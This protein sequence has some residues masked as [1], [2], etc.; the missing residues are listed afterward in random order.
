MEGGSLLEVPPC[1]LA[2]LPASNSVAALLLVS[3]PVYRRALDLVQEH[4]IRLGVQRCCRMPF[5]RHAPLK[6]RSHCLGSRWRQCWC[7]VQLP[8]DTV[9]GA[10]PAG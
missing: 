6:V 7:S 10:H 1:V 5:L 2:A 9:S 3:R 4:T 8:L